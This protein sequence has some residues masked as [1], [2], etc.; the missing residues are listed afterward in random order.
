[1]NAIGSSS[2]K[3]MEEIFNALKAAVGLLSSKRKDFENE[4]DTH[5]TKVTSEAYKQW[6]YKVK[7]IEDKVKE[8][9]DKYERECRSSVIFSF[10]CLALTK[11]VQ[12]TIEQIQNLLE[13]CD[14]LQLFSNPKLEPVLKNKEVPLIK[15][16]ETL[17]KPLEEVLVLLKNDRVNAIGIFGTMGIGKTTIM[18]NLNNHEE[19]AK[20]F[21]IVILVKVSTDGSKENLSKE[22]L[23]QA[24]VRRLKIETEGDNNSDEITEKISMVLK[25][26]TYLILLDDV[27]EDLNLSQ[28]GIPENKNGSKLV[29]TT[30][31]RHVCFSMVD[32]IVKVTNLSPDEAWNMFQH[33][34]QNPKLVSNPRIGPLAWR[35]CQECNGLPLLIEKVANTFKFKSNE[36]LW[37]DGLDSWRM[38]PKK[39]R[40]GIREM[41]EL[42][43]YCYDDLD[44]DMQKKCFLY[45]ALYPE[46]W[47]IYVEHLLGCWAAEG[48]LDND[49]DS[50]M[51]CATFGY[52]VF[53][54]LLSASLL[55]EGKTENHVVMH[56]CM[57]QVALYISQNEPDCKYLVKTN[58]GSGEAPKLESWIDKNAVSLGDNKF[59][60]LPEAPNCSILST[61]FLQKNLG[62]KVIPK[63][64]FRH[65]I[66]LRV[67]D[68]SQ[69]G[70]TLLPSSM[71]VLIK[72]KILC[73]DGCENLKELPS[74]VA[75]L[76]QL[77]T[78]DIRNSG[79]YN[80]PPVIGKLRNLKHLRISFSKSDHDNSTPELD[81][82]YRMF[83]KLP[84]LEQLLIDVKSPDQWSN[85]AVEKIIKEVAAL[86]EFKIL[87]FCFLNKVID[88]IEVTPMTIRIRVPEANI[89]QSFIDT[90]SWTKFLSVKSFQFYIGCPDSENP[91]IPDF[92]R[93]QKYIKYQ[94]GEGSCFP[95]PKIFIESDAFELV[96]HKDIKQLS[97]SE[98][99]S[100]CKVQS[101][102][103]ESCH[104][105]ESIFGTNGNAMPP[106]LEHLYLKSLPKLGDIWRGQVLPG[107]LVK[108]KTLVLIN[109]QLLAKVFSPGVVQQLHEL[110]HLRMEK[111]PSV[112]ELIA[113]D[114]IVGG[115]NLLPKLKEL[116]LIDMPNLQTICQNE[117]LYWPSLRKLWIYKCSSLRSLPFTQDNAKKLKL[118]EAE[119][120]WWDALLWQNED[121]KKQ[122][123]K[124]SHLNLVR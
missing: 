104:A 109:C 124:S 76:S 65:M 33:V 40:H 93:Y 89:L 25:G 73:L 47:E 9:E 68:L 86:K 60:Q 92:V 88:V 26:I 80:M 15:D 83:S 106:N 94:N 3:N 35:V 67:L 72:L 81:F 37:S 115:L 30:R 75:K 107:C 90:Y 41:Y 55:E 116:E 28:L 118:M 39:D 63:A 74:H 42:L 6:I 23:R 96:K 66:N 34:L 54:R 78:L 103:I 123:E 17:Q 16:F 27:K 11:G 32:Q 43:K 2:S 87:R 64:F 97:D 50:E 99:A 8:L 19:V 13:E 120:E 31:F 84:K 71:S 12:R 38:W 100:L 122:F 29:L 111:C 56:K 14:Q 51:V 105:M 77:E 53:S 58:K 20:M 82:D 46:D 52:S 59:D 7:N 21:D 49:D 108:L 45:T 114:D 102:V 110:Q 24:I 62:L 95:I 22:Q 121:I 5:K 79:V 119:Q 70:I 18:W 10:S 91:Q 1:M 44:D 48:F 61:L 98:I 85:E 69:T 57:R 36:N 101:C 112:K 4:V 117:S 113:S